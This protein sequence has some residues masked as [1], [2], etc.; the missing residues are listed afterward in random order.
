[1]LN[2]NHYALQ[3]STYAYMINKHNPRNK[4]GKLSLHHVIFE[5]EGDDQFGYPIIKHD[6]QGNPIVKEIVPYEVP[7]LRREVIAMI[8]WLKDNKEL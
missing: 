1:M 3:L 2:F 7:Y 4:I 5:K 6:S 8:D